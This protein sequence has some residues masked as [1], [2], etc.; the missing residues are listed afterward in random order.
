M[1]Q[2]LDEHC[3]VFFFVVFVCFFIKT[4]RQSEVTGPGRKE[5]EEAAVQEQR[6]LT[7]D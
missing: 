4:I 6:E 7:G 3:R 5:E 2:L 1:I